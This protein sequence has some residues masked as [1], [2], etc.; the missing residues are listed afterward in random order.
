MKKIKNFL[1]QAQKRDLVLEVLNKKTKMIS[2]LKWMGN[3]PKSSEI[4]TTFN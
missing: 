1:S 4:K 3:M 2:G